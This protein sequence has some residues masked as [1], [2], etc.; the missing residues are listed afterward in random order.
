MPDLDPDQLRPLC[1]LDDATR[2]RLYEFVTVADA[3]VTRD[4]LE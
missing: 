2:R 4:A 3:P 1:S